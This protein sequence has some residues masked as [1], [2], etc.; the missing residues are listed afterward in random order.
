MGACIAGVAW[1]AV[2][3]IKTSEPYTT[4]VDRARTNPAVVEQFGT[5]IEPKWWVT[6]NVHVNDDSGTA[7]FKIPIHGPKGEGV[8]EVSASQTGNDNWT[9]SRMEVV[10]PSGPAI[11]LLEESNPSPPES[12]DTDPAGG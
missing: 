6:G 2:G 4:A 5:P 7:N 10:T 9:Y 12:T 8:I 3:A 11:N 1:L